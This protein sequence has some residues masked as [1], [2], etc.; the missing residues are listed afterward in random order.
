MAYHDNFTNFLKYILDFPKS[1]GLNQENK[2]L[3]KINLL[4]HL[5]S[6]AAFNFS[7]PIL[8]ALPISIIQKRQTPEKGFLLRKD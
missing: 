3:L 8:N 7:F 2:Y 5:L 6:Y 1:R 4:M